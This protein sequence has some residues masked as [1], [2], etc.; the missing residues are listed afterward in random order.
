MS[1][2]LLIAGFLFSVAVYPQPDQPGEFYAG[3]R[4]ESL[5][6]GNRNFNA[7][8]YYPAYVEGLQT[9]INDTAGPYPIFAFGHGFLMQNSFYTSIF[10]HLATH[11]YIV[12]APQFP[13][14]QHG[15]LADDL[16]HCVNFIKSQDTVTT[17]IFYGLVNKDK[18]G[19]SGHSMGG[20]ASL[21]AA[22]RD[23][24]ITLVAPLAAAETN[25]SAIARMNFII[26]VVYLIT[27]ENDGITPPAVHQIPMYNSANP[28]KA[29]PVIKGGNHTKF[30]DTAVWDWTD[31]RGYRT[32]ADQLRL[33]RKYLTAAANL[34]LYEEREMW[35]YAFGEEITAD[36]MMTFTSELKPLIPSRFKL[37]FPESDSTIFFPATFNWSS[38]YSLNG[39][40]TVEYSIVIS[41]DSLFSIVHLKTENI[42]DTFYV[43]D[44]LSAG[45][46]FWRVKSYTSDSTY[47]Y[48]IETN[49]FIVQPAVS[50]SEINSINEFILYDN[51]PNPFNPST[52]ISYLLPFT[53]Y[54]SLK[55]FDITGREIITLINN[56]LKETGSYRFNLVSEKYSL[57]SGVYFYRLTVNPIDGKTKLISETKKLVLIK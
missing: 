23:S 29:L 35:E 27:A 42:T 4:S 47:R 34:F 56:E 52:T 44:S 9:A 14:T 20:G 2:I 5:Q 26:G 17:S 12:I 3:W 55:L 16:L 32:R 33:T 28:I 24:T 7:V 40:D 39:D 11:G 53:G 6:R 46:Y 30:M 13:D 54:V 10:K 43:V 18:V 1:R 49:K 15:E 45:V 25:P 36:T 31:P 48:S 19:L 22:S 41:E 21:L 8:I 37:I 38:S 57:T 50:V 51:Y